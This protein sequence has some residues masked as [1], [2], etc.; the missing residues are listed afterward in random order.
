MQAAGGGTAA[1]ETS[2]LVVVGD[3]IIVAGIAFQVATMSICG[4]LGAEF[5]FRLWR[6]ARREG[7]KVFEGEGKGFEFHLLCTTIAF[8]TI[9]I[10]CVYRIPE[11]AGGWG[12]PLMRREAEFLVLDGAMV[13]VAALCLTVGYPGAFFP[14][15]GGRYR[16]KMARLAATTAHPGCEEL[17]VPRPLPPRSMRVG[18]DAEKEGFVEVQEGSSSLDRSESEREVGGE[19]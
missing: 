5:A 17:V 4:L 18:G 6:Q 9:F 15:I 11:M 1:S 16:R 14:E 8:I 2:T 12:N 7:R 19:V 10:R 3:K 13:A